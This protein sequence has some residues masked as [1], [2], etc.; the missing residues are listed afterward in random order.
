MLEELKTKRKAMTVREVADILRLSEREIYKLA[1]T[2]QI[3]HVK[4]G[5][6]IRFDPA[7]VLAWLEERTLSPVNRRHPSSARPSRERVR[8]IA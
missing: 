4:I 7:T 1:A 5:A 6:S 3:P 8:N 2:H